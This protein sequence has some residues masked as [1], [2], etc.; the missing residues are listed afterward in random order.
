MT[1]LQQLAI[2][3]QVKAELNDPE[4]QWRF[5]SGMRDMSRPVYR[6]MVQ[7]EF[8]KEHKAKLIE[9]VLQMRVCP[10]LLEQFDPAAQVIVQYGDNSVQEAGIF[11]QPGEV[12]RESP[13][14]GD[15]G[16]YTLDSNIIHSGNI[17][18]PTSY[19]FFC[20]FP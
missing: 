8:L 15:I 4:V 17:D 14:E 12:R 3:L 6:Y 18:N 9:R 2:D 5:R 19:C 13:N 1:R 16:L 7:R 10:D 20:K 11:L